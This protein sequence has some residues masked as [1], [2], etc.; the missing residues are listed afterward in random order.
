MNLK[1]VSSV[2]LGAAAIGLSVGSVSPA[3]AACLSSDCKTVTY[4]GTSYD[5]SKLTGTFNDLQS[6]LT[7]QIWWGSSSA[8]SAFAGLVGGDLGF[9]NGG[10]NF[11]FGPY[12]AFASPSAVGLFAYGTV[13]S[14]PPE[15]SGPFVASD[16]QLYTYAVATSSVPVPTPALL[17]GLIGMGVAALRKKGQQE[18]VEQEA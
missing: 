11:S 10:V 9:P 12:F 18:P 16:D 15:V 3:A 7:Q 14:S 13:N 2:V 4:Q 8:A 17:P 5:V 6:T 1:T